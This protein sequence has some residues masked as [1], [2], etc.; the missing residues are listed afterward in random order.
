MAALAT[1]AWVWILIGLVT[2]VVM[3]L[4]FHREDWLGG[5]GSWRR[6]MVRLGHV[7][8]FGTGM[9]C[10]LAA[11][12]RVVWPGSVG[13]WGG[14]LLVV[15]AAAMPTVC[16]LSSWHKPLRQLFFFPVL[17]LLGGVGL[18][19]VSAGNARSLRLAAAMV[20]PT[21]T[22]IILPPQ[23]EIEPEER[24]RGE[25]S[26]SPNRLLGDPAW[27]RDTGTVP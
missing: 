2:G 4:S 3:G 21:P 16:F 23:V 14:R 25:Q 9:L 27:S 11:V 1:F 26:Q 6:R 24:R 10:L 5:Y 19:V 15:G 22:T 20:P 7:S 12:T 17:C 18:I 13:P 8:F